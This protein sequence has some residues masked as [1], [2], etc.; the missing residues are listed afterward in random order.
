[1]K[2]IFSLLFTSSL[3]AMVTGCNVNRTMKID[4][5]S[6]LTLALLIDNSAENLPV[7]YDLTNTTWRTTVNLVTTAKGTSSTVDILPIERDDFTL[8][9]NS[10]YTFNATSTKRY[11]SSLNTA[12]QTAGGTTYSSEYYVTDAS[13]VP[14]IYHAFSGYADKAINGVSDLA[15][16]TGQWKTETVFNNNVYNTL[17]YI[18]LTKAV[19][20]YNSVSGTNGIGITTTFGGSATYPA[21]YNSVSTMITRTYLDTQDGWQNLVLSGKTKNSSNPSAVEL[22]ITATTDLKNLGFPANVTIYTKQ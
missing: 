20:T 4:N 10:D 12:L 18:K 9:F 15:S 19:Y 21:T 13:G 22:M 1:M 16:V 5:S 14:V 17:Y 6:L 2:T 3:L 8:V 11:T 7:I